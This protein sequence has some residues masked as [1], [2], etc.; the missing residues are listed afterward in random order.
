MRHRPELGL[1]VPSQEAYLPGRVDGASPDPRTEHGG[2]TA[3]IWDHGRAAIWGCERL[4]MGGAAGSD[5]CTTLRKLDDRSGP[6]GIRRLR[7]CRETKATCE[8]CKARQRFALWPGADSL[9]SRRALRSEQRMRAVLDQAVP[10][11]PADPDRTPATSGSAS[12]L[13]LK[14]R[15]KFRV[16]SRRGWS[17]WRQSLRPA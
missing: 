17:V 14:S 9:I 15:P 1:A 5:A 8:F 2:R 12:R 4:V 16:G 7:S 11:C 13:T 3:A 10:P 6:A